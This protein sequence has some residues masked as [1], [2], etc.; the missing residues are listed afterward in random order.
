MFEIKCPKCDGEIGGLARDYIRWRSDRRRCPNCG[1]G[2]E[3]SNGFVC[4]GVCGLIFGAVLVSSHLWGIE[5]LWVR[6][7]IVV[8][9]C[10]GILPIIVRAVGRWRIAPFGSEA[11]MKAQKWAG[12]A[13][14]SRWVLIISVIVTSV[15]VLLE[16]RALLKEAVD[17]GGDLYATENFLAAVKWGSLIGFGIAGVA[18]IVNVIALIMRKKTYPSRCPGRR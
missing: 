10:W 14:I 1:S 11:A 3:I 12:V 9:I 8:A 2:L 16:Y 6:L 13:H 17:A 18:L 5:G 7:A 15:S 4:F